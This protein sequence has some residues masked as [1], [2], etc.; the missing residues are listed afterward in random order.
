[1]AMGQKTTQDVE[2]DPEEK[3]LVGPAAGPGADIHAAG[4]DAEPGRL[5]TGGAAR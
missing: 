5:V 2:P 1:M 3:K 4:P